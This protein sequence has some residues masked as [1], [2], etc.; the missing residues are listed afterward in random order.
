MERTLLQFKLMTPEA[1]RAAVQRLMLM[2]ATREEIVAR[3]VI[4]PQDVEL[5]LDSV[6]NSLPRDARK[7]AR[8]RKD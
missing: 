2:G 6:A 5:A 4:A 7:R 1:Q 8:V 3:T